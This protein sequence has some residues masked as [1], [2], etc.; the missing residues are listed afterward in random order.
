[1]MNAIEVLSRRVSVGKLVGPAPDKAQM[2][3][4]RHAAL[5]A[6]DHANL[7]PW[8]FLEVRGERLSQLGELFCQ[9]A[10]AV[11]PGLSEA[12]QDRFRAMPSRAPMVVVAIARIVEHPKVP[13]YEQLL[14]AGC[15]VQNMLNAA[16]AMG[17]GA[18]WRTGDLA[19]NPHLRELLGL[20]DSD[21]IV[22]F[23]YLGTPESAFREPPALEPG[24]YFEEW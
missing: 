18:Y 5:R 7:R 1:M 11:E 10:L 16:F 14:S 15:A 22:G 9:A 20:A 13:R 23:V 12:Q 8:R 24:E 2:I 19:L 3:A 4:I 6:A 21:E 17:L